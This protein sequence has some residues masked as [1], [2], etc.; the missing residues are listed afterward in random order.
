MM[1]S[2]FVSGTFKKQFKRLEKKLQKR[3]KNGLKELENDPYTP[4]PKADIIPIKN[5][6]PQKHRIR[7]GDYRIV[8]RIEKDVVRVIEL[9]PRGRGY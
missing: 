7:V 4:R 8:Y 3:I 9:F 2:V 5:T 6:S 1:Y